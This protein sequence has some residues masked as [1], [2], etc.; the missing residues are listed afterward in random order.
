MVSVPAALAEATVR[1]EGDPGRRWLEDLPALIAQFCERWGCEV[2]GAAWHGEVAIVLPV[3]R[4]AGPAALKISF[5]HRGNVGEA[6][7]L[8]HF[9][10][11]G[12]VRLLEADEDAFA[13]LMERAGQE[14]LDS[15]ASVDEAI[16]IAGYLARRLAVPAPAGTRS[17][18][19]TT[20]PWEEEL[21]QQLA[22]TVE[23]PPGPVVD[24]ARRTIRDLAGDTTPTML[25]GDLH[26]GNVLRA[27]REPWLAIDPKGWSGTAA[28][29]VFTVV[30]GRREELRQ[31]DDL[32][33]AVSARIRRFADAAA[34]D[35]D[36]AVACAQAR[37][38][39]GFLY[40]IQQQGDWFDLELLR[41]VMALG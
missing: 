37:A 11:R 16:E 20:G 32:A 22:A 29:E 18:A 1:R 31:A 25:H 21:D 26:Y 17:L 33:A 19:E 41:C 15:L 23:R 5:P 27:T 9:D 34:V 8:R 30:A 12:A 10:G 14:T 39:S 38:T 13:L 24:R 6:A 7:A 3:E 35:R 40:Q 4:D 36:L 28:F 2:V